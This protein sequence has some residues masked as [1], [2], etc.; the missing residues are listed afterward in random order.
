MQILRTPSERMTKILFRK[1]WR[2]ANFIMKNII[3][4][5]Y[6]FECGNFKFI[7]LKCVQMF[8]QSYKLL[9]GPRLSHDVYNLCLLLF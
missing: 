8:W 6:A 3:S 1:F 7:N 9:K 2:D 4:I 5:K